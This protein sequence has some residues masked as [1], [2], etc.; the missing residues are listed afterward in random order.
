MVWLTYDDETTYA[1][2][3]GRYA[4]LR[5][6]RQSEEFKRK[7]RKLVKKTTGIWPEEAEVL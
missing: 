5:W 4:L 7:V 1:T 3:R 2:Y 6:I